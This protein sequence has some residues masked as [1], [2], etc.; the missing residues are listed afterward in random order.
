MTRNYTTQRN[1]TKR[2]AFTDGDFQ[3]AHNQQVSNKA[4]LG[5][6]TLNAETLINAGKFSGL[7]GPVAPFVAVD[8]GLNVAYA[9]GLSVE[10]GD[11][12]VG[13]VSFF[14]LPTA[15]IRSAPDGQSIVVIG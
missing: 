12:R 10:L 8:G 4:V 6:K 2:Y 13:D 15:G 9:A 14:T 1:V 7:I 3:W 5:K 11:V